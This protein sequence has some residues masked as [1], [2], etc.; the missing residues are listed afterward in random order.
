MSR[1]YDFIYHVRWCTYIK[2]DRLHSFSRRLSRRMQREILFYRG[3]PDRGSMKHLER[4]AF[5]ALKLGNVFRTVS[6]NEFMKIA[7]NKK[8]A[9]E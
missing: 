5:F 9:T 3:M 7:K 4:G 2:H 1:L 6:E 8:L